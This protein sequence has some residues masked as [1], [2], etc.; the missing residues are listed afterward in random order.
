MAFLPIKRWV[1][2][3]L[4]RWRTGHTTYWLGIVGSRRCTDCDEIF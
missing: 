3:M 2:W 1:L 4:H